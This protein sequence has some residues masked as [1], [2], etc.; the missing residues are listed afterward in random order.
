MRLGGYDIV[1]TPATTVARLF[2]GAERIRLRFRHR[3]EV[4]PEYIETLEEHGVVFSGRSP[5]YPIMHVLELPADRHPY[6]VATQAHPELTSRPL[7]AQPMFAGLV[8][9]AMRYK[10]VETDGKLGPVRTPDPCTEPQ[11]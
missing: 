5:D 11:A 8:Q 1:V 6:F 10:G 4:N 2:D 9:A 3:Y 7:H